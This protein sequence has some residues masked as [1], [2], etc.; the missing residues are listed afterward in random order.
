MFGPVK[1][2]F[3]YVWMQLLFFFAYFK[4]SYIKSQWHR[5]IQKTWIELI[6]GFFK[7]IFKGIYLSGWSVYYVNKVVMQ[8]ILRLMLGEYG[9]AEEEEEPVERQPTF[10]HTTEMNAAP[11]L[12]LMSAEDLADPRRGS[13]DL[14][15]PPDE[16]IVEDISK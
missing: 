7:G 10:V 13:V 12:S 5:L 1:S 14:G 3:G 11:R 9:Y 4:P 15:Q 2:V 16:G 8:F 6:V